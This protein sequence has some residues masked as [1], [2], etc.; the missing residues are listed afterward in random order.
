MSTTSQVKTFIDMVTDLQNRVR[1]TTGVSA[2][3]TQA[4]RYIN[5]G[6]HD[7]HIGHGEKFW[8]AERSA[9]LVTQAQYT[10]GT[11]TT[12][13]G[14]TTITGDSTLWNTANDFSVNN[15]RVGGKI[16]FGG[17]D[18]YEI[19]AVASDTSATLTT[20][21]IS[22]ALSASSYIYFEDEYALDDDFLRPL[23]LQSFS[24]AAEIDLISPQDFRRKFPRNN[25]TG[26]PIV[27]TLTTKDPSGDVNIRRRVRFYRPPAIVY[28]IPYN[29]VTNKLAISASGVLAT[30][31]SADTD[32]PIVPLTYRHVIVTHA[33]WHWYRDKKDDARANEVAEEWSSLLRRIVGDS[34]V[35][36]TPKPRFNSQH[37]SYMRR[38]R[39]PWRRSTGQRHVTGTRF[40]EIR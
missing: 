22:A 7:M 30:D 26:Q 6:L 33:L 38:S 34:E 13:K 25:V 19:A 9:Q 16:V 29:F 15:M 35:G 21:F 37:Q 8:W 20:P 17:N 3:E 39:N 11:V 32:E 18:V 24:N 27:A 36:T 10:T 40:D 2:T 1:V 14:S 28:I 12:T 5:I 4:K 31:L 23:D